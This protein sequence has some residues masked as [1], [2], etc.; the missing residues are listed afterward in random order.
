MIRWPEMSQFGRSMDIE[1]GNGI[2]VPQL[3]SCA[4]YGARPPG[5]APR[6]AGLFEPG[7]ETRARI[8]MQDISTPGEAL[9]PS[10]LW[11]GQGVICRGMKKSVKEHGCVRVISSRLAT[12]WAYNVD[13]RR[14]CPYGVRTLDM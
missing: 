11:T 12:C 3:F 8:N 4:S 6:P 9:E 7:R 5:E 14:D 2:L 10:D 1:M 13:K